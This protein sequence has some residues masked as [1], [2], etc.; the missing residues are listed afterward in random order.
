MD[1]T[2]FAQEVTINTT[3]PDS[4][5]ITILAEGAEVFFDGQLSNEFNVKRFSE[6]TLVIRAKSGKEITQVPLNSKDITEEVKGGV[7]TLKQISENKT[8]KIFTK[9]IRIPEGKNYIV[10]GTVKEKGQPV[11]GVTLE[12]RSILKTTVTN[13]M[14]KF[15]FNEIGC[16]KHSLTIIKDGKVLGYIELV[17]EEGNKENK[18]FSDGIYTV[19]V[20][21]NDIGINLT[22]NLEDNGTIEIENV[23]SIF[24]SSILEYS[25]NLQTGDNNNVFFRIIVLIASFLLLI[26]V[27]GYS[28]R[29]EN[30]K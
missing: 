16:G 30:E 25:N 22:L 18:S 24:N 19:T 21:P 1:V 23:S 28:K 4:H 27:F 26:L 29:K 15:L 7:Y 14:G 9:D 8:F 5:T 17:L 12:L 6:A 13:R 11:A 3:V 2:V 20:N 10:Q